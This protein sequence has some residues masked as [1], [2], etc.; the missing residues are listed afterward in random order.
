[1]AR[2]ISKNVV[3]AGL[4]EKCEIQLSYA[5]GVPEPTS[6]L[7][8]TYGTNN[9]PERKIEEKIRE[10]FPLKPGEIINHLKLLRPIY[11]KTAAYGH[12]GRS[13]P[14]FTW[15]KTDLVDELKL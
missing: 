7:V 9:I 6:I 3:A 15:E 2:Y 12:F 4:A 5:I 13:E 11:K 14:E 8:N 1:M 10:T